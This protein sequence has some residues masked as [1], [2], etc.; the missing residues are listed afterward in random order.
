[1]AC[2]HN[3]LRPAYQSH[4]TTMTSIVQRCHVWGSKNSHKSGRSLIHCCWTASGEQLTSPSTWFWIYS[5]EVSPVTEDALVLP[6]TVAPMTVFER[7]VN[8]HLH[9]HY[10]TLHYIVYSLLPCQWKL[11][12]PVG[13]FTR[14]SAI[15]ERPRYK[16]CHSFR[17]KS[18]RLELGN[19]ILRTLSVHLQ[20]LWYNW[21]ENLSNSVKKRKIRAITPFKVIQG[22]RGRYQSKVRMR[23]PISD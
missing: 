19:N 5:L 6:R 17:Q 20:P 21:P 22:H 11:K 10:I 2:L 4:R 8:S 3:L 16:V 14:C 9:S 18:R 7:L 1:M 23:F 13:N 15:A 12:K